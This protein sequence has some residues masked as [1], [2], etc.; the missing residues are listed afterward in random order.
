MSSENLSPVERAVMT[1]LRPL[2]KVLLRYSV[3]HGRFS[4]LAKEVY[5]E[6]SRD[7]FAVPGRKAT[8]SRIAIQT[9]LTRREVGR[10]M[11]DLGVISK[12]SP[13]TRFNRAAR[14]VGAWCEDPNYFDGRGGP[15]ALAFESDEEPSFSDLVREYGA[16]VPPRAV[17]DEL[18]GVGTI[19]EQADGRFRLLQRGYIP[20]ADD[21]EK[22]AILGTDVSD[23]IR[24]IDHNLQ[25]DKEYPFFQRKV[26]YDNLPSAYLPKLRTLVARE[27]QR[28]LERLNRDMSQYDRD[29]APTPKG[30][31]PEAGD[32]SRALIGVYFY[33]EETDGDDE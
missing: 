9:G 10:L 19:R 33:E 18:L 13:R 3:A 21:D 25:E 15:A 7:H 12:D 4:D 22:L 6:V 2:V 28:L 16:D 14:V 17:L 24:S 20:D 30:E 23:L 26:S 27:G 11:K 29:S 1:I 8:A 5:V 31:E 32:R